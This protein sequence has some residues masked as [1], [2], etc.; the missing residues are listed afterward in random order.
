MSTQQLAHVIEVELNKLNEMIDMKI[1]QGQPYKK[2]ARHHRFLLKQR[3]TLQTKLQSKR[4]G[5]FSSF[6]H[7]MST[8]LL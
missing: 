8:F 1:I 4:V 6:S 5:F 3:A 2:E 7:V